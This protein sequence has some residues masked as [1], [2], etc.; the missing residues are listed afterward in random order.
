MR[1]KER[2]HLTEIHL[3]TFQSQ[4]K[5]AEKTFSSSAITKVRGMCSGE[6]EA[7]HACSGDSLLSLRLHQEM[8]SGSRQL[9]NMHNC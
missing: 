3:Q 9:E 8:H 7:T 2:G 1:E 4:I 6:K 5:A